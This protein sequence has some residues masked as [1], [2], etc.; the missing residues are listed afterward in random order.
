MKKSRYYIMGII[1]TLLAFYYAILV[2]GIDTQ[3]GLL[4]LTSGCFSLLGLI[5]MSG[6]KKAKRLSA[7]LFLI[8]AISNLVINNSITTALLPGILGFMLIVDGKKNV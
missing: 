6:F 5:T 2:T 8:S 7:A 4:M 1:G 3:E